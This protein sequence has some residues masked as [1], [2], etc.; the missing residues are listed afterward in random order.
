MYQDFIVDYLAKNEFST[1]EIET[2]L[3]CNNTDGGVEISY[4]D[5]FINNLFYGVNLLGG[6]Q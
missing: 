2:S 3:P 5:E 1:V 4:T 6:E